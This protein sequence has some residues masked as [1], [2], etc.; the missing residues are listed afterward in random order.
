MGGFDRGAGFTGRINVIKYGSISCGGAEA[1]QKQMPGGLISKT[2]EDDG[3]CV[4][5]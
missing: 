1:W 4:L 2:Q 5:R 3:L